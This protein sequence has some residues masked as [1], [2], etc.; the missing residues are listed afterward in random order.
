M[1]HR[2]TLLDVR[3]AHPGHLRRTRQRVPSAHGVFAPRPESQPFRNPQE[4][5]HPIC[6]VQQEAPECHPAWPL[7]RSAGPE[8]PHRSVFSARPPNTSKVVHQPSVAPNNRR[9][10]RAGGQRSRTRQ[11]IHHQIG[12]CRLHGNRWASPDLWFIL[13]PAQYQA[14]PDNRSGHGGRGASSVQRD[15]RISPS[16]SRRSDV[17]LAGRPSRR[18]LR[19]SG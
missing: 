15:T 17:H 10:S 12:V 19:G 4:A 16:P 6:V 3:E 2:A 7:A 5:A 13:V 14:D 18:P 8:D 11:T 9:S 1:R